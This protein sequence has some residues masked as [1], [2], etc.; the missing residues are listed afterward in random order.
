MLKFRDSEGIEWT[1]IEIEASSL[2]ALP[3]ESLRYP[4]FKDGWLLFQSPTTRKRLAPYPKSWQ[5]LSPIELE[6]LCQT[7]RPELTRPLSGEFPAFHKEA[8][9]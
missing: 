4:E 9:P 8:A 2:T 7:A 5:Q 3:R 6:D 1:V